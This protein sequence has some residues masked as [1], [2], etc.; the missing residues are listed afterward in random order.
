[1]KPRILVFSVCTLP[2]VPVGAPAAGA[3]PQLHGKSV[4]VTWSETRVQRPV[5]APNFQTIT[6]EQN[7]SMYFGTEGHVFSRWRTSVNGR[8]AGNEQVAGDT[9]LAVTRVPIFHG[10]STSIIMPLRGS[11]ARRLSVDFDVG[12]VKCTAKST[13]GKQVGSTTSVTMSPVVHKLIET[14]SVSVGPTSCSVQ[15]GNVFGSQ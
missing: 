11:A 10:T 12:Y 4:I 13:F 8:S 6:G 15:N 3:P 9:N 7:L 1:M 14:Q 5:G 2:C